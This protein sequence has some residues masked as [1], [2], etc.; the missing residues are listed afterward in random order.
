MIKYF[1][2]LDNVRV[3]HGGMTKACFRRG[4]ALSE[5][6][7]INTT[8]LTFNDE[9]N[10]DRIV[11]EVRKAPD[12]GTAEVINFYSS[13]A[14]PATVKA[15][16]R[17]AGKLDKV[18]SPEYP[19]QPSSAVRSGDAYKVD[20][21]DKDGVER[22]TYFD[23]SGR[24]YL[25]V[26]SA[27]S[28][29]VTLLSRGFRKRIVFQGAMHQLKHLW[30]DALVGGQHAMLTFDDNRVARTFKDYVRPNVGKVF[31]QHV[32]HLEG[33]RSNNVSDPLRKTYRDVFRASGNFDAI[34]TLSTR[35]EEK[36][37][38]RLEPS[39][40]VVT[41]PNVNFPP[42]MS[43]SDERRA[44]R[45]GIV[46]TR[47]APEKQLM[48]TVK[49]FSIAHGKRQVDRLVIIGG[50]QNSDSFAS[51]C[52]Y[53]NE[54]GLQ[55][56][57]SFED[58]QHDAETRFSEGGFSVLSSKYEGFGLVL[59]E[60]MSRGTVPVSYDVP[61]GPR[62]II[63]DGRDGFLV[64][65]GDVE[66]LASAIGR[67]ASLGTDDPI[68]AAARTKARSFEPAPVSQRWVELYDSIAKSFPLRE[69]LRGL[70]PTPRE[71]RLSSNGG[72]F[73]VELQRT[74]LT[75]MRVRLRLEAFESLAHRDLQPI[76]EAEEAGRY[77]F[78]L[79][80]DAKPQSDKN[81]I[82]LWLLVEADGV[83]TRYRLEW[84]T[85]WPEL[86]VSRTPY[87]NLNI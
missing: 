36:L 23:S 37:R 63:S 56:V 76:E 29:R 22:R 12:L 61:Y 5:E 70:A 3:N 8:I 75:G 69:Q 20:R 85:D 34:V 21:R 10:S 25:V 52:E 28:I 59:L 87:G 54:S 6:A 11:N 71:F 66:A 42:A 7:G 57:I 64:P 84:P 40:R 74:R 41:I 4:K 31:V 35:Q 80:N 48:D 82:G 32:N 79:H 51:V 45:T 46:V 15:I 60:A 72:F 62:S 44:P 81:P 27:K 26:D 67:A 14:D 83:S 17:I 30:L 19:R 53:V 86:F 2:L 58:H 50:P 43:E 18:E 49:A 24:P 73:A 77:V 68:R 33:G 13:L 55:D 78:Q 1:S 16:E 47:H 65:R 38:E 9:P 39:C